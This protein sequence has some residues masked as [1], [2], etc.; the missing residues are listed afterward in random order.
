VP[1]NGEAVEVKE[2]SSPV[3][4]KAATDG[5]D[6]VLMPAA[7]TSLALYGTRSVTVVVVGM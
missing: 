5:S 7:E 1:L 6:W 3:V 2:R 4:V